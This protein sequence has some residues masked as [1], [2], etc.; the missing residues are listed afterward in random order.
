MSFV[1]VLHP[2]SYLALLSSLTPNTVTCT[3]AFVLTL[4]AYNMWRSTLHI[5]HPY[6]STL[7]AATV[8]D[9]HQDIN[10]L[11]TSLY[12]LIKS[13]L[14]KAVLSTTGHDITK[15]SLAC[16]ISKRVSS[17][18][19][20]LLSNQ[21]RQ[22]KE[23]PRPMPIDSAA[24][25]LFAA[26]PFVLGGDIT[27][28][29]PVPTPQTK[30][31]TTFPTLLSSSQPVAH[32]SM[33]G[34]PLTQFLEEDT[35]LNAQPWMM[36]RRKAIYHVDCVPLP[37]KPVI[38]PEQVLWQL[39]PTPAI[40]ERFRLAQHED[41][42]NNWNKFNDHSSRK[43]YDR[44]FNWLSSKLLVPLMKTI[45]KLDVYLKEVNTDLAHCTPK[46]LALLTLHPLVA[47]DLETFPV[48]LVQ[49]M[50][51][52]P[53]S[54]SNEERKHV[55]ERIKDLATSRRMTTFRY[56]ERG[57]MPSDSEIVYH[58]FKRYIEYAMPQVVPPLIDFP[59]NDDVVK[60]I[61]V[62]F[63]VTPGLKQELFHL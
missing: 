60:F 28:N 17:L 47:S 41:F 10:P 31:I 45:N 42:Q 1:Q 37:A 29:T 5:T 36:G 58:A 38:R 27:K 18:S 14:V 24:M 19:D 34:N 56:F 2:C 54:G 15:D 57:V 6:L 20:R 8:R 35:S 12:R 4:C 44:L 26:K 30:S 51:S 61:L 21:Q 53:G 13:M 23:Q 63:Y 3:E 39:N 48:G 7:M 50:L 11:S 32:K 62:F 55:I 43:Y 59:V 33:L 9:S 52:L 46:M 49:S 16:V 25:R 40:I 22:M